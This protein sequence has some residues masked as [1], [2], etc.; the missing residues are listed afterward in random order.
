MSRIPQALYLALPR[1]LGEVDLVAA[2]R[3]HQTRHFVQPFNVPRLAVAACIAH[4][5]Q[6]VVFAL[7]HGFRF[8]DR[9]AVNSISILHR[10][11]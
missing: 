1:F 5:G 7:F 10:S 9:A 11:T 4:N 6:I 8:R 2:V 3:T